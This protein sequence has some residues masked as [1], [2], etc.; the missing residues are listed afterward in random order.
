MKMNVSKLFSAL[1]LAVTVSGAIAAPVASD[2]FQ[3]GDLNGGS[4]WLGAWTVPGGKATVVNPVLDL[5]GD[6]AL[7]IT[8]NDNNA[9]Y[10]SLLT[11]FTGNDLFVSFLLQV[12][13]NTQIDTNDFLSLWLENSAQ[14]GGGINRPNI[15]V[16]GNEDNSAE[17]NDIFVRSTGTSG[18]DFVEGSNLDS[19]TVYHIVGRLYRPTASSNYTKFDAWLN[20]TIDDFANP[21]AIFNVNSGINQVSRIGFRSAN[22]EVGPLPQVT[23]EILIDQVILA[24]AWGDVVTVPEPGMLALV[25][26]GLFGFLA[27]RRRKS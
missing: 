14:A 21:D 8:G 27:T 15:G 7:R 24:T 16:K 9:A 19:D 26:I 10:R 20:P 1:V 11:P 23:D 3:S 22:L 18:G 6:R 5:N 4:G 13:A 12:P 17:S 2:S 25:G